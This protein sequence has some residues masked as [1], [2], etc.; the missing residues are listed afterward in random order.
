MKKIIKLLS[1]FLLIASF[2]FFLSLNVEALQNVGIY[3]DLT[4][5]ESGLFRDNRGTTSSNSIGYQFY[6]TFYN[7]K[8]YYIAYPSTST[9]Y[10][11]NSWGGSIVQCGMSFAKDN[12]YS[13]SYYFKTQTSSTLHPYYTTLSNKLAIASSV[14]DLSMPNFNYIE[15]SHSVEK[16]P[17]EYGGYDFV[18]TVVFKAPTYGTCLLSAFS[19]NPSVN[20]QNVGFLGYKYESLGSDN[21]S[22]ADISNALSNKFSDI[23]N[24]IDNST[25]TIVGNQ[26]QN[27]QEIID[28]ANQNHEKAEETRKGIWA[29]LTDG[30]A[31][32]GKWFTD[33][34]SSI[35]NFFK[36]LGESIANGFTSLFDSIKSLFVGEEVCEVTKENLFTGYDSLSPDADGW[37]S[38]SCTSTSCP[39]LIAKKNE[40]IENEKFY[41][42]F[43]EIKDISSSG[44]YRIN[45]FNDY[46]S[47]L[48]DTSA[49]YFVQ[50]GNLTVESSAIKF[51]GNLYNDKSIRA[52]VDDSNT[53]LTRFMVV[54]YTGSSIS[55]KFRILI[56]DDMTMT[57]ENYEYYD[58]KQECTL[59]GGLFGMITNFMSNVGK[60]FSDLLTGLLEGLKALFIPDGEYFSTYFS[61]LYDF[62]VDKLGIL[63]YPIDLFINVLNRFLNLS[64]SSTGL[65]HIP[66]IAI[67]G[68]GTLVQEQSFYINE[69]WNEGP[70]L[71]LYNIYKAFVSCFVGLC[72][73]NLARKKEKEIV[74][75]STS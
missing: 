13:V 17:S 16:V 12:Y 9:S 34:A 65:I 44:N 28:N 48:G 61:S 54:R 7:D 31:N 36:E 69:N 59:K 35:G 20:S 18:Y 24:N 55:F 33:L 38:Y 45:P 68:F 66:E 60:W 6:S 3:S 75:G 64:S 23:Q 47:Q 22:A 15:V 56:T 5:S 37:Y 58:K 29:S 49:P 10:N 43:F 52:Y 63:M 21:L 39:I 74:E 1:K 62:F 41:N 46:N 67:P 26:E 70:L 42:T 14:S 32:I 30:I 73:V 72:L 50:S 51:K 11:Y 8:E 53:N 25:N 27:K 19:G 57:L 40:Q 2:S 4:I 71:T